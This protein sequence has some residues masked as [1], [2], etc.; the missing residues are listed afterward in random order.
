VLRESVQA[1]GIDRHLLGLRLIAMGMLR[2][3]AD[4]KDFA[5][6]MKLFEDEVG[7]SH[8]LTCC[9]V[10]GWGKLWVEHRF[11]QWTLCAC[12]QAF[13]KSS[14]WELSTSNMSWIRTYDYPGFGAPT[15]PG[16][17]VCYNITDSAVLMTVSANAV[18][19]S[20]TYDCATVSVLKLCDAA[21]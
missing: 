18:R 15:K 7:D 17:G 1:Q 14:T 8:C 12:L 13:I 16:Y 21:V 19:R 5:P 6:A 10:S 20:A 2:G 3:G 11:S 9:S 4:A